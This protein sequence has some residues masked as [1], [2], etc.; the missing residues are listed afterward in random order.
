MTAIEPIFNGNIKPI[1][2]CPSSLSI[3]LLWYD[4]PAVI[5]SCEAKPAGLL[6]HDQKSFNATEQLDRDNV[7]PPTACIISYAIRFV[8]DKTMDSHI[9]NKRFITV[10][11]IKGFVAKV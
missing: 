8:E 1:F 5:C 4:M 6:K 11:G 3:N 10:V 9:K 7:L 2:L